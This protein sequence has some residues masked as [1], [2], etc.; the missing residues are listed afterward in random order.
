MSNK[1]SKV[2]EIFES[3]EVVDFFVSGDHLGDLS[4][5]GDCDTRGNI[6]FNYPEVK[7]FTYLYNGCKLKYFFQ[8]IQLTSTSQRGLY[9][10][11]VLG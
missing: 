6:I 10:G 9:C 4:F 8:R 7:G 5:Q 2:E 3:K 11:S 1:G